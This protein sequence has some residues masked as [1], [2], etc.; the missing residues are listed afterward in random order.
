[1]FPADDGA[2]RG[3]ERR[4]ASSL[5]RQR[6]VLKAAPSSARA[7][8]EVVA[9]AAEQAD[10]DP[11][12]TDDLVLATS[13]AVTNAIL[14]GRACDG[15]AITLQVRL[16]PTLAAITVEDCGTF[17]GPP[18]ASLPDGLA[19][20]GRGLPIMA[21]VCDEVQVDRRAGGTAVRLLKHLPEPR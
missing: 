17:R 11:R 18:R 19:H 3:V 8:R 5:A 13:E 15:D 2:G 1:M 6:V 20:N 10:L 16:G 12:A 14:H 21:I 7:A 4:Q 9:G